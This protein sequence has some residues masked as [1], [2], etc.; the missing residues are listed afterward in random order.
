MVIQAAKG[1]PKKQA[2]PKK[3]GAKA[4]KIK[5]QP[6]SASS[7]DNSDLEIEAPDEPSPI[8]TTR[9]TEPVAA[10]EY[11]TLQAVWSPRN[12]RPAAD[13]VKSALVAFK[14]VIKVLRD[15]WKDQVQAMKLAENQGNN[16]KAIQLKEDVA[17][18][19]RIMD[20]I[21]IITMD[22][23]HPMIVEK[24]ALPSL[25]FLFFTPLFP[26]CPHLPSI[27]LS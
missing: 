16:A 11:D 26:L 18:Q 13:K 3:A 6:G 4:Q 17:L 1:G 22:M 2:K 7:S 27:W 5:S 14:D 24:Y 10:A 25:I 9:P 21:V 8:P 19:R 20:K 23:G 15:A 12:K